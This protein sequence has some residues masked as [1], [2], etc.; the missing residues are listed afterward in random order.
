VLD[1]FSCGAS[2][3]PNAK[4]GTAGA[5]YFDEDDP[6]LTPHKKAVFG[7]AGH[8]AVVSILKTGTM[9]EKSARSDGA[10]LDFKQAARNLKHD[11][12]RIRYAKA[13][14]LSLSKSYHPVIERIARILYDSNR[15]SIDGQIVS[16]LVA[17]Y[18]E[19]ID[20]E[21]YLKELLFDKKKGGTHGR[22]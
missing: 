22:C 5:C 15:S 4:D 6:Y 1:I 8:A 11:R 13:R 7:Y 2:I 17:T 20:P 14:A 10:G 18:Q 21:P 19:G 16:M 9:S 3:V 12:K